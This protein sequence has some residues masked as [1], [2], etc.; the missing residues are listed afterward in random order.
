MARR[1]PAYSTHRMLREYMQN[2]YL[3]AARALR[4][5]LADGAAKARELE[6]WARRLGVHWPA[7]RI[8]ARRDTLGGDGF[9]T[10]VQIYLDELPP[11]DVA[12]ELYADPAAP[13]GA[14]ERHRLSRGEAL[15]GAINGFQ[16]SGHVATSRPPSHYTVRIVPF[17]PL[18]AVPLE[19]DAILWAH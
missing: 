17:H 14:P 1:T 3:P 2:F 15:P 4:T 16:Y 13:D 5:R 7:L 18:A 6:A 19:A 9:D 8:G 10:Q 11:D 12:V